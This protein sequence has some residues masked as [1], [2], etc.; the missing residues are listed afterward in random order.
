MLVAAACG[1]FGS[2]IV[3]LF[4]DLPAVRA[5]AALY[6]PWMIVSVWGHVLDGGAA[7][8]AGMGQSRP[9]AGVPD[10]ML[11]RAATLAP[12][13]RASW[14]AWAEHRSPI[15]RSRHEAR[16][17]TIRPS[18]RWRTARSAGICESRPVTTIASA[19]SNSVVGRTW[20][21]NRNMSDENEAMNTA[22]TT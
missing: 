19:V 2:A 6:L 13:P 4:T 20:R 3:A 9:L 8:A 16:S 15:R 14:T 18:S 7:A 11:M 17:R 10:L 22:E 12:G 5:A 1:V 21:S